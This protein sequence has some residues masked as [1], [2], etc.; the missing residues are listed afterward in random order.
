MASAYD[1][2][3]NF[4][5]TDNRAGRDFFTDIIRQRSIGQ[6]ADGSPVTGR[7]GLSDPLARLKQNFDVLAPRF[8]LNNPQLEQSRFSLR[9]ELFRVRDRVVPDLGTDG[10]ANTADELAAAAEAEAANAISDDKWR[11]ILAGAIVLDLWQVPEFRR[12]C[13]PFAPEPAGPQPGIVLRF[14]TTVTFGLNFFGRPLGGGD[15]A[16]DPSLFST[17]INAAG[18]WFSDYNGSGLATAPRVYLF[19]TGMDVLRSPTGNTLATREWRVVDQ[20]IPAPFPIGANDLDDPTWIPV[21]DSLAESFA[22]IRRFSSFRAYHDNG[23]Y[24]DTETTKS[25][26]LVGRSVWNTD[27]VLIIP[28]GTLLNNPEQGLEQLVRAELPA[29]DNILYGTITIGSQPV[30]EADTNV[31]VEARRTAGGAAIASY[32]MGSDPGAGSFYRLNIPLEE[33][34]PITDSPD[35]SLAGDRLVLVV[36]NASG[37]QAQLPYVIPERGHAQRLDFG[38]TVLDSDNDGLP[39]VWELATFGNLGNNG[40]STNNNGRTSLDNFVT[41]S[42]PNDPNGVFRLFITRNGASRTVSFFAR[43][44]GGPGYEGYT[45]YYALEYSTNLRSSEW[46]AVL[47]H[48]NIPGNNATIA[49]QTT[50]LSSDAFYRGRVQLQRP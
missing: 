2:E 8:G 22:Q 48:T 28:G 49:Y 25:S 15:T 20:A 30:A 36:R 21:N 16:Y 11:K 38:T 41:G 5:G 23:V 43:R 4:L 18:I 32:R 3:L 40:S 14:P 9:R 26:R 31:V 42:D 7:S 33:L 17:K 47:S 50:E 37:V 12:Y 46:F 44:S 35:S 39:D 29:P 24:D 13:R 6:V 1:Y 10:I 27:W 34:P 45:R 19:P